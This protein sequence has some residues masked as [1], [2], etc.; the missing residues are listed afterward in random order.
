MSAGAIVQLM[1]MGTANGAD[2]F[3]AKDAEFSFWKSDVARHTPFVI[4]SMDT[5]A[6][7]DGFGKVIT[8]DIPK[9]GDLVKSMYLEITLGRLDPSIIGR[10]LG[11]SDYVGWANNLGHVLV[12]MAELFLNGQLVDRIHGE[13]MHILSELTV[14]GEKKGAHDEMIGNWKTPEDPA[15]NGLT[16][17]TI[18]VPLPF[19][20]SKS[21][22]LAFPYVG[23][24]HS[25]FKLSITYR[26]LIDCIR[27]SVPAGT[28]FSLM[29]NPTIKTKLWV[30]YVL[31]SER[32]RNYF[33]NPYTDTSREPPEINY[34]I[35]QTQSLGDQVMDAT[36]PRATI[37]LDQLVLPIKEVYIVFQRASI[38]NS[39][40]AHPNFNNWFNY[41][42]GDNVLDIPSTLLF[43][44]GGSER[45]RV[46]DAKYYRLLQPFE[47]HSVVPINPESR[48]YTYS[49]A[50]NPEDYTQPSGHLN[51]SKISD[52]SVEVTLNTN[53]F[54]PNEK[55]LMRVYATNWNILSVRA[56]QATVK[57]AN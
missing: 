19:W 50:L 28:G 17:R 36:S 40:T 33:A 5:D 15:T 4:D 20:F 8:F 51:C 10:Q 21:T 48:I 55:I 42:P 1:T 41:S 34:L 26:Q 16:E 56:A 23:T 57:Y 47:S 14:P 45:T 43:R 7:A 54:Q 32:E 24:Q 2:P 35:S 44:T 27:T 29:G 53:A 46:R 49:F 9:R 11:P 6:Q 22:G 13:Y 18:Y 52:F 12:K 39:G 37:K 3:I 25:E 38:N 31:L 30:D